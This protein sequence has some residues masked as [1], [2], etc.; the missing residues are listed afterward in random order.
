MTQRDASDSPRG[1]VWRPDLRVELPSESLVLP[2]IHYA[3]SECLD[4]RYWKVPVHE[5]QHF[6]ML[7]LVRGAQSTCFGSRSEQDANQTVIAT[8][9]QVLLF[10]PGVPHSEWLEQDCS[11][12]KLT[13][14]FSWN[15]APRPLPRVS[16]DR[17][18]RVT[19]LT[20][21]L[22]HDAASSGCRSAD[23]AHLLAC[24]LRELI[25][26][27][28]VFRQGLDDQ[29]RVLVEAAPNEAFTVASVA[30]RLGLS[31]TAFARR[32]RLETG[33]SPMAFV[34][35]VRLELA[36][37]LILETDAPLK[38]IAVDTG[39]ANIHHLSH[40]MRAAYQLSPGSIRCASTTG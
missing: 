28:P 25:R 23:L 31:R 18:G 21:W 6:E 37:R 3:G 13:I 9:S 20:K 30:A 1:E 19:E 33:A 35:S 8:A 2:R 10:A 29:V 40:A 12:E 36:R 26:Q 32:F 15:A 34:Q 11:V 24:A 14:G 22:V 39:F 5:H 7:V 27:A 16:Q 17:S 38:A 4:P